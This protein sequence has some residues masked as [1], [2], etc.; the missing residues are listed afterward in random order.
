MRDV[1]IVIQWTI[2]HVTFATLYQRFG[3]GGRDR[4][5]QA[6]AIVYVESAHWPDDGK[7]K[8]TAKTS[9]KREAVDESMPSKRIKLEEPEVRLHIASSL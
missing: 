8:S 2:K 6:L 3:R 4:D 9:L 7:G 5:I 1:Q